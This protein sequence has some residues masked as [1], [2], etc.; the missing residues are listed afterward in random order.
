MNKLKNPK[1]MSSEE[2]YVKL[3]K[4]G[5]NLQAAATVRGEKLKILN[6]YES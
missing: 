5:V 1:E 2:L 3:K 4:D 6:L